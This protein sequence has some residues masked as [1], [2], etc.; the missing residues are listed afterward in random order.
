[1]KSKTL[2]SLFVTTCISFVVAVPIFEGSV[3]W[4]GRSVAVAQVNGATFKKDASAATSKYNSVNLVCA[5]YAKTL[6]NFVK[7]N[8]AKYKI[9]SYEIYKLE[10]KSI[11]HD[12]YLE[13][14]QP[15][16][17][18]GIHYYLEIDGY[19]FDNHHPEGKVISSFKSGFVVTTTPTITKITIN[20]V[21]AG[22]C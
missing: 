15:I 13:G 20:D 2:V 7:P 5:E 11:G 4:I 9:T 14:K 19:G 18:N 12:D 16:S 3:P 17:L 8:A 10:A 22:Q 21:K 6:Y 1:M